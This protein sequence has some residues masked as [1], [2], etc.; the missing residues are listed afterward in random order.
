MAADFLQASFPTLDRDIFE[1]DGEEG[2]EVT[3]GEVEESFVADVEEDGAFLAA[4]STGQGAEV[5]DLV[6]HHYFFLPWVGHSAIS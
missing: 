1:Q 6:E 2:S 3:E 5:E 4:G